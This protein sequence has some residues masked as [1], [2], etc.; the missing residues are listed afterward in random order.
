M[1]EQLTVKNFGPI[2][3]ATVDFKRVTVFIGPTG[4]GKSTL[5]KLKDIFRY[6]KNYIVDESISRH[7]R[8][9]SFDA[10]NEHSLGNYFSNE[11]YL[12]Y[13]T[14]IGSVEFKNNYHLI[15]LNMNYLRDNV[16]SSS[17]TIMEQLKSISERANKA[18]VLQNEGKD[19]S[20]INKSILE[21][22]SLIIEKL[23]KIDS[24]ENTREE[25][26]KIIAPNNVWYCPSERIF[27]SAL[28]YSWAGILRDDIGLPRSILAFANSFSISRKDITEL[29]I[30]L[31]NVKYIHS[32]G[33]DFIKIP[34]REEPL[35]L[36]ETAS[37]IQSV[38]P[39]LVLLEHLSRQKE[40]VQSFII[41]EPELNLYPTAQQG[42]M[43][44]LVEK[45]TAGEN[46][47]TIT[48]HSPYIL[49]H[50]NLLLYA[51]QVA[52]NHP[53]RADDVAKLVPRESWINPKEFACYQVEGGGVQSLVDED[54]GLI[55][56][57]E[58]DALSGDAADAFDNLIRLSKSVAV[59]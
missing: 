55:D 32:D 47:L 1:N 46:D 8:F 52:E 35:M 27:V 14:S 11:T 7:P 2:K 6:R 57:N 13:S 34:E 18:V 42:L 40:Q 29:D 15:S 24:G 16:K 22:V 30:P 28:E 17:T 43:N 4:G 41:E 58:L 48:T 23:E 44:W 38:T 56:N 36:L 20:E 37:G 49:S 54:L 50:L 59:K 25:F 21:D 39:M 26:P 31:F 9:D 33:R 12:D 45:C 10:Y 51:Y 19:Y 53:D 5:A 3:D